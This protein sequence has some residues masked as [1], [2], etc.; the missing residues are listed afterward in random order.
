M[1]MNQLS[2]SEVIDDHVPALSTPQSYVRRMT[3][4]RWLR[5]AHHFLTCLDVPRQ[6]RQL[7][8]LDERTLKDVGISRIDALREA[9]RDFWDIPQHLKLRR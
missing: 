4:Q 8:A 9:N 7:L 1:V 5:V 3:H 6:R 2:T